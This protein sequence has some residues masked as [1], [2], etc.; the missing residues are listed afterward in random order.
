MKLKQANPNLKVLLGVGGWN[1]GSA[2]FSAIAGSDSNRRQFASNVVTFLRQHGFDGLDSDWEYPG[3]RG[4][5][6]QD[7]Q[8]NVLMLQ[9]LRKAFDADTSGS[10]LL[11]TTAIGVGKTTIDNGYDVPSLSN[12][13]DFF[14]VMSYD[15]H[16]AFEKTTG[17]N[18]PLF[19]HTGDTG[20]ARHLNVEWAVNY[21]L[22][23]GMPPAK[24]TLGIPTYGRSFTLDNPNSH[25]VGASAG[26]AGPAGQYSGEKGFISY[27]EIC[28]KLQ[29]GGQSYSIP[30][31]HA[32]YMVAGS[33]WIGY[34]DVQSVREKACWARSLGLGGVMY[35]A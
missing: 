8:N 16:G 28:E 6:P 35:W 1:M 21:L 7:K 13:V 17:H 32:K 2:P 20:D 19:P 26:R 3:S 5:P 27:Y 23:L 30:S 29:N 18:S 10:P 11:L 14:N 25:S 15:I 24:V 33:E 9:E 4:S 31:Q 34:D 12:I 22:S